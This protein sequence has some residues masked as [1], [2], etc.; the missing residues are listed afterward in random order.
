M[1]ASFL[2][3]QQ[4]YYCKALAVLSREGGDGDGDGNRNTR[5]NDHSSRPR[6]YPESGL[7]GPLEFRN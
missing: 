4:A 3:L 7:P 2:L 1:L 6:R 5:Q